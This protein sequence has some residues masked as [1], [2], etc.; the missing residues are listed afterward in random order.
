MPAPQ[1]DYS[2]KRA[3]VETPKGSFTLRFFPETAPLHVENFVKLAEAGFYNGSPF[4][5]IIKGFMIQGGDPQGTGMGGHSWKG[6][7]TTVK[8]EFS[9]KPHMP[10]TPSMARTNDP[11]SA[12]SQFFVCLDRQDFLDGQ[13]TVFGEVE[14][15][16]DVVQAI[17]SVKTDRSD[18]PLE[19]MK[20]TVRVHDAKS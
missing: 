10:G 5:R 7:G 13:Y 1:V 14:Q 2:K 12:G 19:P 3:V 20:M 4:H 16:L 15:G 6:P 9:S 17:G 8:A 11:N 18:R